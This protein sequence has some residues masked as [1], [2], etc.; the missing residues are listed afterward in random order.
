MSK[1]EG[2]KPVA[3]FYVERP[4]PLQRYQARSPQRIVANDARSRGGLGALVRGPIAE[5][6][7]IVILGFLIGGIA[8]AII[9]FAV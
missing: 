9:H 4:E 6:I 3:P 2:G 7:I 5:A 1:L 8:A